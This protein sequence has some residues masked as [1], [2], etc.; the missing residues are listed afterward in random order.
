MLVSYIFRQISAKFLPKTKSSTRL[1]W[2]LIFTVGSFAK[3]FLQ[4]LVIMISMKKLEKYRLS[5]IL[6]YSSN[7]RDL[8]RT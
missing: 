7:L 5:Y 1:L 2:R 3:H 6:T 4:P 8:P